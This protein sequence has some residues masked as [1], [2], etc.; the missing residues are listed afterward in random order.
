VVSIPLGHPWSD[1]LQEGLRR[2]I[3][4]LEG[5][6]AVTE[7]QPDP[8]LLSLLIEYHL[9]GGAIDFVLIN[10]RSVSGNDYEVHREAAA[11]G[12]RAIAT[13]E[14]YPADYTSVSLGPLTIFLPRWRLPWRRKNLRL[15]V[16][17]YWPAPE[18]TTDFD[19][20]NGKR[21]DPE[22]FANGEPGCEFVT[23]GYKGAFCDPPYPLELSVSRVS[24]LYESINKR[25]FGD[26]R[27][28]AEIYSWSTDWSSYF[29]QSKEWWGA[30]LWTV[31]KDSNSP[32]IWIGASASD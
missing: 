5:S 7:L 18:L 3:R 9:A 10:A 27:T 14:G 8:E 28:V 30:F 32:V 1:R 12:L 16:S 29:D 4:L 2:R 26:L 20:L 22:S 31:R 15:A 24:R 11:F 17:H 19:R 23:R 6:S 21:I 25:L 13:R